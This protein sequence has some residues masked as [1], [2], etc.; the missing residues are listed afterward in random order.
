L[1]NKDAHEMAFSGAGIGPT[2]KNVETIKPKN[3]FMT[4]TVRL[5]I[6]AAEWFAALIKLLL[7][8]KKPTGPLKKHISTKIDTTR[9]SDSISSARAS[10]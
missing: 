9:A 8:R 7:V 2:K 6:K 10:H 1:N 5:K 3:P 4:T